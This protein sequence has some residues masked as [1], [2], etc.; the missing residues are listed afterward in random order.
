[1]DTHQIADSLTSFLRA[2]ELT[3]ERVWS[4]RLQHK[5]KELGGN[6]PRVIEKLLSTYAAELENRLADT[7]R[8]IVL[9]V[10]RIQ[11]A[12]D[13]DLIEGAVLAFKT[14]ADSILDDVRN[15]Y[16]DDLNGRLGASS[17]NGASYLNAQHAAAVMWD[18]LG[19]REEAHNR[20][21]ARAQIKASLESAQASVNAAKAEE[22]SATASTKATRSSE[23][24]AELTASS[25][26][27]AK[28]AVFWTMIA[29]LATTVGTVVTLIGALSLA[30]SSVISP[31]IPQQTNAPRY[32][33]RAVHAVGTPS[34]AA[35]PSKLG[36]TH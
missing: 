4:L 6:S 14:R 30:H 21:I 20:L 19:L 26:V 13:G 35:I 10:D 15:T 25:V 2:H 12:S 5:K 3:L 24:L 22:Q 28:R 16:S 1:M 34:S 32:E 29:A 7:K 11:N 8:M 18:S 27:V 36:K 17:A 31:H 23:R 9:Y 33:S